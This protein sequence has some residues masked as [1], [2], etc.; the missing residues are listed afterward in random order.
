V[1]VF[2]VRD[3]DHGCIMRTA[4][5]DG[6]R[7]TSQRCQAAHLSPLVERRDQREEAERWTARNPNHTAHCKTMVVL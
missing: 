5:Q 7:R 4:R 6:V 3:M 2:V 1:E